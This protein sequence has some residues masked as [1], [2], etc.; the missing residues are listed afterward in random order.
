MAL[1]ISFPCTGTPGESKSRDRGERGGLLKDLWFTNL[2]GERKRE[3]EEGRWRWRWWRGY[4][5]VVVRAGAGG[6]AG[7][8]SPQNGPSRGARVPHPSQRSLSR[9]SSCSRHTASTGHE[10]TLVSYVSTSPSA[11]SLPVLFRRHDLPTSILPPSKL[12]RFLESTEP[13]LV[14][15]LL[16]SCVTT[17]TP[18]R[19]Q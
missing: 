5:E 13:D 17:W 8:G 6:G 7:G 4:V 9:Q 1:P 15:G 12:L 2:E 14:V 19:K 10:P 11:P 3:M 18:D 16:I